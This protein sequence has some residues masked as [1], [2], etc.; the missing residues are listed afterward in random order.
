MPRNPITYW[1]I[2]FDG[3]ESTFPVEEFIF[4]VETMAEGDNVPNNLLAASLHYLLTGNA[5]TWYWL[6]KRQH[7]NVSWEELRRASELNSIVETRIM[8]FGN[9]RNPIS[10]EDTLAILKRNV[11]P[12]LRHFCIKEPVLR[13][14]SLI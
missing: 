14:I 12:D 7:R 10:E 6:F 13:L 2:R 8:R 5:L 9:V 3:T 4:R 11:K 1:S